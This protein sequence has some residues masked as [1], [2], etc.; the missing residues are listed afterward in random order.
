MPD[1]TLKPRKQA[2]QQRSRHT[3][4]CILEGAAHIFSQKGYAATTTN[5]I[6][7]KAGVSIGSLYQYFPNKDA[8]V[9]CLAQQH[10]SDT[11]QII[12]D[13]LALA[14]KGDIT[15]SEMLRRIVGK[16]IDIHML[17]PR[18]H[19]AIFNEAPLPADLKQ[20]LID[21]ERETA[22]RLNKILSSTGS[23]S[24]KHTPT[25]CLLMVQVIESLSHWYAVSAPESITRDDMAKEMM[26][27]IDNYINR[28]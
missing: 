25:A 20:T 6:A 11:G 14:E 13:L 10:L 19:R 8:I 16:M 21:Y 17:A 28:K 15:V 22:A 1:K 3:V 23:P 2:A 5:H 18:L 9:V 27:F 26:I 4:T 24:I 7:K 12:D